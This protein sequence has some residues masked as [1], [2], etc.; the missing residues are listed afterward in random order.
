VFIADGK[1]IMKSACIAVAI[2]N[3]GKRRW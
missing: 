3:G 2:I 1:R